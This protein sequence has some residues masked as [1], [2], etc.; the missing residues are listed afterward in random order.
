[1]RV[2]ILGGGGYVGTELTEKLL[3]QGH[4]VTVLD[5]FWFGDHILRHQN[6]N[7]ISG[8][9]RFQ[10]ALDYAIMGAQAVI[11]LAC[12]SNDPCFELNPWLGEEI[13]LHSFPRVLESIKKYAVKRFIYA[14]SSSVYGIKD[15]DVTEEVECTPL[16]DYSRF[17]L[18]CE[19]MLQAEHLPHT[20][21]T[22]VRPATVCGYSPRMRF[23]LV[24]NAMSGSAIW[25]NQI[26]VFGGKQMRANIHIQDM[27]DA[28]LTILNNEV[29]AHRK[30]YNIGNEN[31]SLD[32]ISGIIQECHGTAKIVRTDT[33]DTRSYQ[34]NS[35]KIKKELGFVPRRTIED[36]YW[37]I[38][39]AAKLSLLAHPQSKAEYINIKQMKGLIDAR[40][41]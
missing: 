4:V 41:I 40:Q 36:A 25:D 29:P 22:I 33:T 20:L 31:H 21:W 23:D 3:S 35:D 1:M 7:K 32:G 28:Y 14:S 6:L 11:H 27:V 17:K 16:T 10:E 15:G 30:I 9:I 24:V 5:K 2:T 18:L 12:V 38:H 8:D 13:N 39:D 37:S 34:I 19:K 26:N